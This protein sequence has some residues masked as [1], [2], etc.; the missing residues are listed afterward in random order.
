MK[1]N[2]RKPQEFKKP[3]LVL[4][5]RKLAGWV[6]LIFFSW[7]CMFVIGVLVGRDNAPIKFDLKKLQQKQT[8]S[9]QKEKA[10]NQEIT[11]GDSVAV[12]DKT[13]LGFY[14]RL[15]EDQKDTIVPELKKQPEDNQKPKPAIQP[16]A[17]ASTSKKPA[18]K[19]VAKKVQP[20]KSTPKTKEK[21]QKKVSTADT[22]KPTGPVYTVQAASV[23]NAKDA[24]RLVTK[25]KKKGFPAYRTL[26]KVPKKGI[27]FRIRI[28]KYNSR[29][30]AKKTLNKLKKLGLKPIIVK[31]Q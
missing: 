25:L 24:D 28:G 15:P 31:Q 23:K 3:F 16:K 19:A 21:T 10:E 9:L 6:V 17:S 13:K 27:W 8:D 26:G 5:R 11:P 1:R 18:P 14:E 12:K 29:A 4:N 2:K 30:E 20:K 22:K 7:A